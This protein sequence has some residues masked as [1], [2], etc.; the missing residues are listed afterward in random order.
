MSEKLH[1]ELHSETNNLQEAFQKYIHRF[2]RPGE[3]IPVAFERVFSTRIPEG[4]IDKANE[5]YQAKELAPGLH[6]EIGF[7]YDPFIKHRTFSEVSPYLGIDGGSSEHGFGKNAGW[8]DYAAD[9]GRI[10]QTIDRL[11][12]QCSDRQDKEYIHFIVGD[13]KRMPLPDD[14]VHEVY[15]NNV[16]LAPGILINDAYTMVREIYRVLQPG[17]L[18]ILSDSERFAKNK[19]ADNIILASN[20][21]GFIELGVI[22]DAAGFSQQALDED[23][24]IIYARKTV[25]E[26]ANSSNATK[27]GLLKAIFRR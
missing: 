16:L 12:A 2:S 26:Q 8:L 6:V 11:N 10:T 27:K 20:R 9:P 17:G 13:A 18:L 15:M 14:S 4:F 25:L 24:N 19:D 5:E 3:K 1:S 23:R 7:G 22:I 21:L